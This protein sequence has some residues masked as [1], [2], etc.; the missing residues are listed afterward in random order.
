MMLQQTSAASGN[1]YANI[2]LYNSNGL[3]GNLS[4]LGAGYPGGQIFGANDVVFLGGQQHA[5]TNLIMLTNTSGAIKFG[6]GGFT[7]GNERLRIGATGGVSIGNGY[8]GTDPGAGNLIVSGKTG[9]GT[10]TPGAT[11]E[12]NGTAKFDGLMTFAAG[13]TF[14]G[15]GAGTIT[16]ITTT[17]PL[18]GSGTTGSVAL[19]LE[20]V[21]AGDDAERGLRTA[22]RER[23]VYKGHRGPGDDGQRCRR[24]GYR[25]ERCDGCRGHIR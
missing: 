13:Q 18:T 21:G 25:D 24:D 5:A 17:S 19:G 14:P 3:I 8:V 22:G 11:L 4:A 20:Y 2:G 1:Y 9:I 6:T 10:S 12:V 23:Y 16:G 7:P 15:T